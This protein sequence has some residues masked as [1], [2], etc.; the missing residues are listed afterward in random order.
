MNQKIQFYFD[1]FL[2]KALVYTTANDYMK[3]K[4]M[5]HS[6]FNPV[7]APR[8]STIPNRHVHGVFS[9]LDFLLE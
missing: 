5:V 2:N 6:L 7:L 8:M 4:M 1:I 9:L 3:W